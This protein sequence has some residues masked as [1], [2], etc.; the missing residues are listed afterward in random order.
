MRWA[1]NQLSEK[2]VRMTAGLMVKRYGNDAVSE[3]ATRADELR[4]RGNEPGCAIW[5]RVI[6]AIDEIGKPKNPVRSSEVQLQ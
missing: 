2:D 3:A 5:Q 1:N 6:D 4:S